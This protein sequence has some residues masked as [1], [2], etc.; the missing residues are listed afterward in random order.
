MRQ[1]A[2]LPAGVHR[3]GH[4]VLYAD[5]EHIYY[6]S[7]LAVYVISRSSFAIESILCASDRSIVS[8]A[9]SPHAPQMAMCG[10]D[11][12]LTLWS[13]SEARI[14]SRSVIAK[15][16]STLLT[17]DANQANSVIVITSGHGLRL[18]RW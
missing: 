3:T 1:L 10:A 17:W 5:K 9:Y 14:V 15:D 13:I 16:M 6:R 2:L 8:V 18:H 12:G 11:G 4:D 7:T